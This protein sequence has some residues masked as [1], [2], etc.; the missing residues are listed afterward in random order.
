MKETGNL[1]HSALSDRSMPGPTVAPADLKLKLAWVYFVLVF[2]AYCFVILTAK[3]PPPIVDYP[4]WVYQ[5]TLFHGSITG[6]SIPGYVLKSYP[7]PFSTIIVGLGLLDT[8]FTWQFAGKLWLC[9]YFA[10]AGFSTWIFLRALRVKSASLLVVLPAV[11]FLNTDFWWGRVEYQIGV[12]LVMIL[13]ALTITGTRPIYLSLLLV[14]I[15]FTHMEALACACLFLAL[16]AGYTRQWGK[17]WAALPVILLS[18]WYAVARYSGGDRDGSSSPSSNYLYGSKAFLIFKANTYFKIFGYINSRA[19]DGSSQSEAIFGKI[20]FVALL[21]CAMCMGLLCM[22]ILIQAALVRYRSGQ[23]YFGVM[24]VSL[25]VLSV[26]VPQIFLG[27]ADP[28]SRLLTMA[29]VVGLSLFDWRG[30]KA[31]AITVL[32]VVFCFANLWQFYRIDN[33]PL[34][35]GHAK[36]LPAAMLLFGHIDPWSRLDIYNKLERGEMDWP[37]AT[38]AIYLPKK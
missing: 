38:T 11:V 25:I 21:I 33:D 1:R 19:S 23:R 26:F 35:P 9:L 7:V 5:G 12:C 8:V 36:D 32:A 29:S 10:L 34:M 27:S 6:H 30:K 18:F 28:G 17:L 16:W 20:F 22:T 3:L 24:I 31:K 13:I 2:V 15:Y 37:I 14:A 4:E